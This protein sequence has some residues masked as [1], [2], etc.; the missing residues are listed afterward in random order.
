MFITAFVISI[1]WMWFHVGVEATILYALLGM[2]PIAYVIRYRALLIS[3]VVVWILW[4]L[5]GSFDHVLPRDFQHQIVPLTLCITQTPKVF[6]DG[7]TS[8]YASVI[9]QP[10]LLRLRSIKIS[11][12]ESNSA[13]LG[14]LSAGDC[15]ESEVRLKQPLGRII[16]GG[17]NADRYYF[18]HK[19]DA[20]GSLVETISRQR[21]P[22]FAQRLYIE[23]SNQFY[24]DN[25]R[26]TWAA[27]ALGWSYSMSSDLKSLLAA[28]QIMHLFVVSGMHLA[29]IALIVGALV[30]AALLM[31]SRI[32]RVGFQCKLFIILC[33]LALYIGLIGYPIPALRSFLMMAIPLLALS[34]NV[35]LSWHRSISSTAFLIAI[36]SPESWLAIGP[37]LSFTSVGL[38]LLMNRWRVLLRFNWL[39]SI[40][41]FQ[42]IMTLSILPWVL[43][44]GFQFNI[45]SFFI[46]L[47]LTPVVAFVG[48]PLVG[49]ISVTPWQWPLQSFVAGVDYLTDLLSIF[50]TFGFQADY[51]PPLIIFFGIALLG[52][53]CW[54]R[55]IVSFVF[56]GLAGLISV[57]LFSVNVNV[58]SNKNDHVTFFDVGHGQSILI[59]TKEMN[60]LYDT[61]GQ[62]TDEVSY[63]EANLSRIMPMLDAVVVS[64]S[65]SDHASGLLYLKQIQPRIAVW[66][67]QM[68]TF[69]GDR[70]VIDCH[71]YDFTHPQFRLI[72]IPEVFQVSDN[73]H[74]CV[75][76]FQSGS[77]SMV[78]TGD[79]SR[80][81]E[82]YLMQNY[83]KLMPFDVVLLG[84]HGSNSSSAFDWL[85]AHQNS[86]FIISTGDRAAPRWPSPRIMR[87][88]KQ[89]DIEPISTAEVGTVQ[90][91]FYPDRIAV[92]TWGSAYRF[93]LIN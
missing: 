43:L 33:I 77:Y 57:L 48:L 45:F 49:L 6:Q 90:L 93:R 50:A 91:I 26:D 23:K 28:N 2:L 87:W 14:P 80:S 19:I 46:N 47:I 61:G 40:L 92:K 20:L 36:W 17:F 51:V 67:S 27:L 42:G 69:S 79:A 71:A 21:S 86:T 68:G 76:I 32:L 44:S 72:P 39:A 63:F 10:E 7:F 85:E 59:E 55:T 56:G 16:P 24:S 12:N 62:F 52:Y 11:I 5:E 41:I 89:R 1:I 78:L 13:N 81:I 31:A 84:H 54:S 29:F 53:I 30:Q 35:K 60:L 64:H 38:I 25:A 83:S 74:S 9:K 88:F 18:S 15:L 70:S 8:A 73:D 34:L 82:Y 66:S 75:L 37:W 3:F 65:D 58:I 4:S 22:S